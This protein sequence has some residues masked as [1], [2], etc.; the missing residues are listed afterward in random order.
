ML[1][2]PPRTDVHHLPAPV[3]KMLTRPA[4]PWRPLPLP[5]AA[6]SLLRLT[7]LLWLFAPVVLSA[8]LIG[9]FLGIS[10]ARWLRLLR[11]DAPGRPQTQPARPA[12]AGSQG[13]WRGKGGAC[14]RG[15][16]AAPPELERMWCE[17]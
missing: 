16:H 14:G 11:W 13:R 1:R 2:P 8:P 6:A 5:P 12:P 9:D 4:A 10:R 3:L 17:T 7:C 15:M